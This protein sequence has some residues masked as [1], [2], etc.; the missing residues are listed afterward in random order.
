MQRS[1]TDEMEEVSASPQKGLPIGALVGMVRRKILL[2]AGLSSVIIGAAVVANSKAAPLYEGSFR[3]LV[4]PPTTEGKITDPTVL[5]RT[6][7]GVPGRDVISLDYP[8][9]VEI[10]RSPNVLDPVY[11]TIHAKYPAFQRKE[12]DLGLVVQRI[13]TTISSATKVLEVKY[14][15]SDAEQVQFILDTLSERYLKY[16]LEE[17]KTRL[18]EGVKFIENQLPTLQQ[19]VQDLQQ[20]LQDLQQRHDLVDPGSQGQQIFA[21]LRQVAEQQLETQRQ[22]QEQR[23]LFETLQ[24]QLQLTP[25]EAIAAS[26]LSQD[27]RYQNL[28]N[29]LKAIESQIATETTRFSEASPVVRRLRERQASLSAL[30]GQ[31]AQQILGQN[32]TRTDANP[33]VLAFQ[34]TVRLNLIQQLVETT[35]QIQILTVRDRTLSQARTQFEQQ[36]EAFPGVARQY[37]E[38]QRQLEIA[39]RTLDQLLT[40]RE[41]LRVEAAQ[42]QLPWEILAEPSIPRDLAGTPIPI[43]AGSKKTLM[44]GVVAGLA[45]GFGSAF[46]L[47]K[48][49]NI[50]YDADDIKDAVPVPLLGKIP[51]L[52]SNQPTGKPW[53]L[54]KLLPTKLGATGSS[55]GVESIEFVE[56]FDALY[57]ALHFLY[58]EQPVRSLV[59]SSACPGDGKSTIAVHLA[60]TVVE[61]GQRVLLVDANLRS[62]QIHTQLQLPNTEGLSELLL[63]KVDK[64]VTI[65]RSPWHEHLFVLTAGQPFPGVTRLLA[66]PYMENLVR[67]FE[68]QFDLVIYDTPHLLKLVDANF[69]A[70]QTNGILLV[71]TVVQTARTQMMET[72]D[73]LKKYNLPILGVVANRVG[74]KKPSVSVTQEDTDILN[75]LNLEASEDMT[76]DP[77]HKSKS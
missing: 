74:Q 27:P 50:F 64:D 29:E 67:Q 19:R 7:G 54:S 30:L 35:N 13:G 49:Q 62:P 70:S 60:K 41:T 40:Q 51:P 32:L 37:N 3:L 21:D 58:A 77:F 47:E 8:T 46:L 56:A 76:Y 4:E 68:T 75:L 26:T 39:T 38:I 45:L 66:S 22:L 24:Q 16:S 18:S 73:Q 28:L 61:M 63:Q 14:Q 36:A 55:E 12:L 42:D 25:D 33:Q 44:M 1:P 9:Q 48:L 53:R 6:E 23:R 43:S 72:L 57:A 31:E 15:G 69:L 52:P 20:K 2:I 34:N 59:V 65:Q 17:R 11:E 10:L 71:I 5:T